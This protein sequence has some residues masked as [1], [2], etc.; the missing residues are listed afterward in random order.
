MSVTNLSSFIS[1]SVWL[2]AWVVSSSPIR[3]GVFECHGPSPT[4]CFV[5]QIDVLHG[6]W[7]DGVNARGGLLGRPVEK[8]ISW[9]GFSSIADETEME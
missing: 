9:I 2:M 1:V 6:M 5:P 4:A 3:I 8:V 7:F